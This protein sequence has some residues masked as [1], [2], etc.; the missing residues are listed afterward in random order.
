MDVTQRKS[1][2]AEIGIEAAMAHARALMR[3]GQWP[4]AAAQLGEVTTTIPHMAEA[5]RLL[6][7]A[8]RHMGQD[9][10]AEQAELDA[11]HA[12]VHDPELQSSA[13]A[14]LANDLPTAEQILRNRLK[15]TPND[16]AAIRMLAE[17]AGRIGRYGDAENLL[18][19]AL[20]LAPA[21]GAARAN[22]ATVLY[23]Q[24]RANEAISELDRLL[25]DDPDNAAHS[26]LKAAALGRVGGYDEALTLYEEL[27]AR[28][29]EHAKIWM[30][31][32]H[33]L[34]TV[35]R[36][37]DSIAA[38]RRALMIEPTLGELWWSLANLKTLR[39]SPDD[40]AAMEQALKTENLANADRY[41]LHFALG[42][43]YDDRKKHEIAFDHYAEGNRLRRTGIDY[44]PKE[45]AAFVARSRETFTP[46]LIA[47]SSGQGCPA[48]DPIF[49]LGMPRAGSTLIEQILSSHSMIEGTMELPDIP[50]IALR[51]GHGHG[52]RLSAYLKAVPDMTGEKLAALGQ[53][54]I[55]RTQVQ[56]KT[57]KPR[58]I[59]KLP[60]NWMHVGF[61]HLI[62][63]NAKII[64]ARRH[65]L[66]CCFSNFKQHFARGQNFSYSLA[67]MGHYYADYVA[68]MKHFDAL[69]P[70]RIH[71][72]VHEALIDDPE[73]EIRRMLDYL[74]LEFEPACLEFHKN[75]R[76]VR[77]AS[78]EQVR[79]PINRDGVDQWQH[80]A[81]WLSPL[82]KAL[83]NIVTAYPSIP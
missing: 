44:H 14:L 26:N 32:G 23:R 3:A 19:R 83:G 12:S 67:D 1:P 66:D 15:K 50:A 30:S 60:N 39:F 22:L 65:P 25:D 57:G 51:E 80:Y 47:R 70:G 72:V 8:L 43:A 37:D 31:F 21:F 63:P 71:R 16:V 74:G 18:R 59:D 56:R 54:Y 79:R 29:P 58:F 20:E 2:P 33:I 78:S 27:L 52:E 35:G 45:N 76:A 46:A 68:L 34:K 13:R 69:L 10:A 24:N 36:S 61:I 11:I 17:L 82:E 73:S 53:D 48:P 49:I 55:N 42:K 38:Y 77:T 64:D 4:L 40:I 28:F 75:D 7:L 81:P 6:A 9:E 5:H 41:H 62:L